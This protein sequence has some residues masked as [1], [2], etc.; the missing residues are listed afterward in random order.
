MP[1]ASLSWIKPN[2]GYMDPGRAPLEPALHIFSEKR[3]HIREAIRYDSGLFGRG[4]KRQTKL[5][6]VS[7]ALSS[8]GRADPLQGLGREFEP[9]SAHQIQLRRR[10][11]Q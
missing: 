5:N 6:T 10:T 1:A 9:L 3:L 4:D 2:A 11:D 8:V 7:R